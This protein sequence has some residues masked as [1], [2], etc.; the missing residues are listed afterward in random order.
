MSI[1]DWW[2]LVYGATVDARRM[3]M[4]LDVAGAIRQNLLLHVLLVLPCIN[5][6]RGGNGDFSCIGRMRK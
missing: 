6:E 4:G 1:L 5:F 2:Q 3:N